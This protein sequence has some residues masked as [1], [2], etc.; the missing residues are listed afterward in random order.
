[1]EPK[2][3]KPQK[4]YPLYCFRCVTDK[5]RK[6]LIREVKELTEAYNGKLRKE[7]RYLRRKNEIILE[8]MEK[9]LKALWKEIRNS[10]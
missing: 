3:K 10:Q 9:G 1:M 7:G 5:R 6:D 8:A 2:G 4:T